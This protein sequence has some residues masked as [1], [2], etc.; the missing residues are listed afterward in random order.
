MGIRD[1]KQN[2]SAVVARVKVGETITITER[3]V[4]VAMISPVPEDLLTSLERSGKLKPSSEVF[5]YS[6]LHAVSV[7]GVTAQELLD[8]LRQDRR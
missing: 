3:G 6:E 5:D 2:A 8:T 7:Q 4:P 1:L